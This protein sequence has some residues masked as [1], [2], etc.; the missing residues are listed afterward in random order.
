ML[1]LVRVFLVNFTVSVG[2]ILR[3]LSLVYLISGFKRSC[4]IWWG[5]VLSCSSCWSGEIFCSGIFLSLLHVQIQIFCWAIVTTVFEDLFKKSKPKTFASAYLHTILYLTCKR[6][7]YS[8]QP[9]GF[10]K[11]I[12]KS[13]LI[14][15][16]DFAHCIFFVSEWI[17]RGRTRIYTFPTP[18]P[19]SLKK[20]KK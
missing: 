6:C 5:D 19:H 15:W 2:F 8:H 4:W 14:D 20:R 13:N 3:V 7:M 10:S 9:P 17:N 18:V 11:G 12:D 16:L 1:W